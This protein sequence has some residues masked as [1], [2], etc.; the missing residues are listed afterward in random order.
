MT[1]SIMTIID[2]PAGQFTFHPYL[3]RL[4]GEEREGTYKQTGEDP[5]ISLFWLTLIYMSTSLLTRSCWYRA[6]IFLRYNVVVLFVLNDSKYEV[7]LHFQL[8]S[9]FSPAT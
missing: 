3:D 1:F 6:F 2:G 9:P 4:M 5:A 7:I 8:L